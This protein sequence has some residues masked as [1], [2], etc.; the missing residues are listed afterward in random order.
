VADDEFIAWSQPYLAL[1]HYR[2]G[3]REQARKL[4]TEALSTCID[5]QGYIPMV[6]TL[7]ITL[8]L[9]AEEDI[10]F[11]TKVYE[12]VQRDPFM[13]K[14]QLFHDL[15]YKHLPESMTA[16][17]VEIVEHN[18]EHREALWDTARLV[19]SHWRAE[20]QS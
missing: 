18:S 7:P 5:I 15:V 12:Q 19:L 13:S 3:D 8:L 20:S 1:A 2:L 6:F 9:L 11:A 14:A 4:L 17:P 10:K 16:T